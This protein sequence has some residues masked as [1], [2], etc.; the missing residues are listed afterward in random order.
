MPGMMPMAVAIGP[1]LPSGPPPK[2]ATPLPDDEGATPNRE[3]GGSPKNDAPGG[4]WRDPDVVDSDSSDGN[5]EYTTT[6]LKA[7][8]GPVSTR[9]LQCGGPRVTSGDADERQRTGRDI[10]FEKQEE[11]RRWISYSTQ[12]AILNSEALIA[13]M[14]NTKRQDM[15]DIIDDWVNTSAHQGHI[16]WHVTPEEGH[17]QLT[18]GL[19]M[20]EAPERSS[21][22][23]SSNLAAPPPEIRKII[24]KTAIFVAKH[25]PGSEQRVL[26]HQDNKDRFTFLLPKNPYSTPF[27][28]MISRFNQNSG[29]CL[30]SFFFV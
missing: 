7:E 25:G 3:E 15:N 12:A 6:D 1:K 21:T 19:T 16:G 2:H 29:K 17:T 13:V 23:E 30:C 20:L 9:A 11:C 27:R 24:D 18:H 22:A 5:I 4:V 8:C 26:Q 28:I 10:E 14:R